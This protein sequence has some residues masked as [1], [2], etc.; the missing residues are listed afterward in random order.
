MALFLIVW[1][2]TT[3]VIWLVMSNSPFGSTTSDKLSGL[4]IGLLA[5]AFVWTMG[6]VLY[7]W[8]YE[9]EDLPAISL[10]PI[11]ST[12]TGEILGNAVL[13]K[14]SVVVQY[15]DG[16]KPGTHY[17]PLSRTEIVKGSSETEFI[18][19]KP[20]LLRNT[21]LSKQFASLNWKEDKYKIEIPETELKFADCI[22]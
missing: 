10:Y 3:I 16:G 5:A 2:V 18:L 15:M 1:T 12:Y 19:I 9:Y 17:L 14:D 6:S 21:W 13:S 4:L 22:F 20:K 8:Q 11:H 7:P